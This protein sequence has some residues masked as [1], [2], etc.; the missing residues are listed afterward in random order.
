MRFNLSLATHALCLILV[1]NSNSLSNDSWLWY[2]WTYTFDSNTYQYDS[3]KIGGRH[4]VQLFLNR[5]GKAY[6][7][8]NMSIDMNVVISYSVE[9]AT[10]QM[11][12]KVIDVGE[13][14]A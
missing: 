3:K 13:N 7:Y 1:I 6:D 12:T 10:D 5:S 8:F 14:I 2:L 11:F 4:Q 9:S